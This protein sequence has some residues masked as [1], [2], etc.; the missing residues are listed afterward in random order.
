MSISLREQEPGLQQE[1]KGFLKN[2]PAL[3]GLIQWLAGFILLTKEEQENA[4]IYLDRLR[5]E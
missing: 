3:S 1:S 2:L 4:G 5:G